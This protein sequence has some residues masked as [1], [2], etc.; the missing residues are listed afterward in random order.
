MADL[1]KWKKSLFGQITGKAVTKKHK[2]LKPK[3]RMQNE[4][5]VVSQEK[6]DWRLRQICHKYL[7]RQR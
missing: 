3:T 1:L 6:T 7:Q 4:G 5:K 2:S